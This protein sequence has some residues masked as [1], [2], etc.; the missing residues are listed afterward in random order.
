MIKDVASLRSPHPWDFDNSHA[1]L[2]SVDGKNKI[3]Y[4]ELSEIG[5]GA[6]L[7]GSCFWVDAEGSEHWVDDWCAGPPIWNSD[8]TKAAIPAWSRKFFGRSIQQVMV[9][10]IVKKE[11]LRYEPE[12]R[13]L[14]LRSF[15]GHHI[16]GY[17]SPVYKTKTLDFDLSKEKVIATKDL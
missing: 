2:V 5:M 13:L 15:D 3:Q 6:P 9:L 17:D 7:G 11:V 10:G 12:F 4:G 8:G 16:Y 14:D 1:Q